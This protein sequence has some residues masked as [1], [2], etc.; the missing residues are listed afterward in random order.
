MNE[1]PSD[2]TKAYLHSVTFVKCLIY[3][4]R[5]RRIPAR[6]RHTGCAAPYERS[7]PSVLLRKARQVQSLVP[8]IV[9]KE[10]VEAATNVAD[11]PRG[12]LPTSSQR[13]W[14]SEIRST[15]VQW[16]YYKTVCH[17]RISL[18]TSRRYRDWSL[19]QA[20]TMSWTWWPVYC[21]IVGRP[22]YSCCRVI[23]RSVSV[24]S[25]NLRF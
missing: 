25:A 4:Y 1:M 21:T 22:T 2:F 11:V 13:P 6:E 19:S 8:S 23:Q 9:H 24:T 10:A 12:W 20:A 16:W 15:T 7:A 14:S 18:I 3:T 17:H 5:V